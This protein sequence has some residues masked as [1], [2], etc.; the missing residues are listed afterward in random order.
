MFF[1][2]IKPDKFGVK[3]SD[4]LKFLEFCMV[5]E[6]QSS[7]TELVESSSKAQFYKVILQKCFYRTSPIAVSNYCQN[8]SNYVFSLCDLLVLSNSKIYT[9]CKYHTY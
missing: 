1:Y 4:V 6:P 3:F 5:V 9:T 7:F 8:L 2:R